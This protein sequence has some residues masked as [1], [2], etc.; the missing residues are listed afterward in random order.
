MNVKSQPNVKQQNYDHQRQAKWTSSSSKQQG[1]RKQMLCTYCDGLIGFP[2]GHKLHG[3]DVQ[4]PNRNHKAT[5]NQTSSEPAHTT[6][7][8]P[9]QSLQLTS[10]ELSQIKAFL[11]NDK[12]P[13]YA[14]YTGPSFEEDDWLGE[15]V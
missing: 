12:S 4:P 3:K 13:P 8:M 10:D 14:N 15:T 9:N 1:P 6:S 11:R 2:I 7:K 5:S